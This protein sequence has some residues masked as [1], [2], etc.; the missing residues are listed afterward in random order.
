MNLESWEKQ[1][2]AESYAMLIVYK[3]DWLA[4]DECRTIR[5]R[6]PKEIRPSG[7]ELW[8]IFN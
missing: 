4:I 7:M 5:R 8:Y 1:P 3:V 6:I 2:S